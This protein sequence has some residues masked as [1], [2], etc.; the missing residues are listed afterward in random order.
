MI[1]QANE[2]L[3]ANDRIQAREKFDL[4]YS[5]LPETCKREVNRHGTIDL[6]EAIVLL[7]KSP[8]LFTKRNFFTSNNTSNRFKPPYSKSTTKWPHVV[9]EKKNFKITN[10]QTRGKLFCKYH[11]RGNHETKDCTKYNRDFYKNQD[12]NLLVKEKG[13]ASA[14]RA[15]RLNDSLVM[16]IFDT[17]SSRNV[18]SLKNCESFMLTVKPLQENLN[19]QAANG[20]TMTISQSASGMLEFGNNIRV[21]TEFLVADTSLDDIIL[22]TNFMIENNVIIKMKT[23]EITLDGN[24]IHHKKPLKEDEDDSPDETLAQKVTCFSIEDELSKLIQDFKL[25]MPIIGTIPDVTHKIKFKCK[26]RESFLQS[27]PYQ[28]PIAFIKKVKELIKELLRLN[29]IVLSSS[30]IAS[31]AFIVPKKGGDI[32][33]VIDFRKLNS[34][35]ESDLHHYLE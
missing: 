21:L 8:H 20:E 24:L 27:K 7:E 17:G 30:P 25:K 16:A 1:S 29:I 18:I 12:Q 19:L 22:G 32:R 34:V 31:P 13:L 4:F 14:G 15:A 28:L 3:D 35:T 10:S 33:L 6:E 5:A 23:G 11:K 9:N 2:C 26:F